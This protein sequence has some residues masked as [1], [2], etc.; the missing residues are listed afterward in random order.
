M[1][2]ELAEIWDTAIYKEIA[3]QAL[4]LAAQSGTD[5]PAARRML[6]E[7]AGEELKHAEI[8]RKMKE[9]G[10]A[11]GEWR[12][13]AAGDLKLSEYMQGPDTLAGAGMQEVLVFAMKREQQSVIF[14]TQMQGM[15]KREE[16]KTL[17]LRLAQE[18]LKHKMKLELEYEQ[19]F[20]DKDY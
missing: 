6:A 12:P 3:T 19:L 16:A 5:D 13:T 8:L 20:P 15:F 14:Y 17:C 2:D 7:L 10:W 1:N 4:Y 9:A 11:P 18:E